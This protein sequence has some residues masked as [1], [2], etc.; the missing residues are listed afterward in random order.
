MRP[1]PGLSELGQREGVDVQQRPGL[2][3][4]IAARPS[5]PAGRAGAANSR[6]AWSTFQ[7]VE[8]CRPVSSV[9]RI[10]PQFVRSRAVRIRCSSSA[11]SAHRHE[12]GT[13]RRTARHSP[14]ARSGTDASRHRCQ[15]VL[16]VAVETPYGAPP[17]VRRAAFNRSRDLQT[18]AQSELA[19]TV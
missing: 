3:P 7:I 4:L 9:R 13:G 10:G 8:R 12:R 2:R 6:D 5:A 19:P 1:V 15:S 17:N 16:T 14:L 11:L 18:S